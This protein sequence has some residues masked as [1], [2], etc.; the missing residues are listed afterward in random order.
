[1]ATGEWLKAEGT[2]RVEENAGEIWNRRARC[3][4]YYWIDWILPTDDTFTMDDV[5]EFWEQTDL[6]PPHHPN[7]IGALVRKA[8]R[9]GIMHA[10]GEFVPSSRPNQ[11]ATMIPVYKAGRE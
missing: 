7:A 10:T 11:R 5:W 1:M 6:E 4:M 2:A 3:R 8:K 9:D